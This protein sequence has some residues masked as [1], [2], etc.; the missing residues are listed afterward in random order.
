MEMPPFDLDSLPAETLRDMHA[1]T[2]RPLLEPAEWLF[3]FMTALFVGLLAWIAYEA[4]H[5]KT[6]PAPTT[7]SHRAAAR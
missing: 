7:P 3:V 2:P 1:E 4:V 5:A 6:P